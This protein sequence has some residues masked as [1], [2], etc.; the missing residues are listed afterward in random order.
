[1]LFVL[2]A[3]AAEPLPVIAVSIERLGGGRPGSDVGPWVLTA[4]WEDGRIV[5]AAD[6]EK[7]GAPF[8]TAQIEL[9]RVEELLGRRKA[10]RVFDERSLRRS[11]F[12]PDSSYHS[13]F[14]RFGKR[15]MHIQTWHELF[16]RNPNLVVVNGGVTSLNGRKR[17]EVIREDTKEFQRFRQVW[18]DLREAITGLIPARGEPYEGELKLNLPR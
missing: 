6:Q 17:E 13:I 8:L 11:W 3:R 18:M 2:A 10:E 5:W 4:V 9:K 15:H 1:M 12:G 16:E 14:L 7:G